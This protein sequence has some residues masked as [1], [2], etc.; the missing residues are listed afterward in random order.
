MEHRVLLLKAVFTLRG[1]GIQMQNNPTCNI[2]SSKSILINDRRLGQIIKSVLI[3]A[4]ILL[5]YNIYKLAISEPVGFIVNIYEA[6]S[7]FFIPVLIFCFSIASIAMMLGNSKFLRNAGIIL[8]FLSLLAILL[9]PYAFDYYSMGRADDMSYIGEYLHIVNTGS[10]SEWD[11]YPASHILGASISVING[12][13]PNI[14]SFIIPI[15]FSL[16]FVVG[17]YLFGKLLYHGTDYNNILLISLFIPYLGMYH[18]LNTPHALFFAFIPLYFFSIFKYINT[19]SVHHAIISIIFSLLFPFTHPFILFF[20]VIFQISLVLLNRV[21]ETWLP[22]NIGRLNNIILIQVTTFLAWFIYSAVLLGSFSR[23]INAFLLRYTEPVL[24]ETTEKIAKVGFDPISFIRFVLLYYGRYIIPTLFI[25]IVLTFYCRNY[26]N[27]SD[28]KHSVE[29]LLLTYAISIFIE[30]ILFIN[31]IISHQPDRMTNLLFLVYFQIPF[32]AIAAFIYIEHKGRILRSSTT[33]KIVV[34]GVLISTFGISIFGMF[35]SPYIL[36]T[37]T[38]LTINEA[39]GMKWTYE[40]RDGQNMSA[41]ISQ[42]G[43]FHD[44]FDDGSR[45]NLTYIPDHF[46]YK[47]DTSL[48]FISIVNRSGPLYIILMKIDIT[49]YEEVPGWKNVGRYT[50]TD[51]YQFN[52][53]S[54]V[55]RIYSGEDIYISCIV[56]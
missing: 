55:N 19:G 39:D 8:L 12:I 31:P 28:L 49:M 51:F 2:S 35:S 38:A 6:M 16:I 23:A 46:G 29:F 15:C 54:S 14:A 26:H 36:G 44:L 4:F 1:R 27:K 20:I 30:L 40:F 42:I 18:F 3:I 32:F 53:D 11:I 43:R 47:T 33:K 52:S 17:M 37:N 9:I 34:I 56:L 41:P 48:S 10:F 50:Y 22:S 45:D 24:Y 25:I 21:K 5:T 7:P 13:Y